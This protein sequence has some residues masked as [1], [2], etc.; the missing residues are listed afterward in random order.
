ML[1]HVL[2]VSYLLCVKII[3]FP[4]S[5]T[6]L[7][8]YETMEKNVVGTGEEMGRLIYGSQG[9][10]LLDQESLYNCEERDVI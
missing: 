7:F 9:V 6:D 4:L 8:I 10:K 1:N 3:Y 2:A 5:L